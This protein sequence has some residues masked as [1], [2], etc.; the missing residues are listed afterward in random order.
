MSYFLIYEFIF[1]KEIVKFKFVIFF[2]WKIIKFSKFDNLENFEI[3]S[4]T[5]TVQVI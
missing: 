3:L 4:K 1:F 2:I 5:L